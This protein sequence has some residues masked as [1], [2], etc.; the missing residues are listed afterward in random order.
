MRGLVDAT[1]HN[2]KGANYWFARAVQAAPHV[3]FAWTDW[4]TA[5]L[6]DGDIV[7]AIAALRQAHHIAPH[8][9]DP[10]ELWGEV[11]IAQNRSDL[12]VKKFAQ[13]A[14]YAPRWGRLH[15]KWAEA[16]KWSG[17]KKAARRE[18]AIAAHLFLT[19]TERRQLDLLAERS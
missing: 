7:G 5:R 19:P 6:H 17:H 10:L 3:P 16:L 11:L 1:L 15:L 13:A 8:F 12:A 14:R 2:S 9:A 4:G 18:A